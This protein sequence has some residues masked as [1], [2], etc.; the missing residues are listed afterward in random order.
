MKTKNSQHMGTH[1]ASEMLALDIFWYQLISIFLEDWSL[2]LDMMFLGWPF[3]E[4]DAGRENDILTNW[5]SLTSFWLCTHS[6]AATCGL[7][8]TSLPTA[9]FISNFWSWLEGKAS[10][11][12]LLGLGFEICS[13]PSSAFLDLCQKIQIHL[14]PSLIQKLGWNQRNHNWNN[15]PI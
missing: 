15:V 8:E 12:Q 5:S 1:Y 9:C 14:L 2:W 4:C 13:H 11:F 10:D 6:C 3:P 7:L